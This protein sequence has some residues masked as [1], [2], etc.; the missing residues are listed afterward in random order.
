M[1]KVH[2]LFIYI[3]IGMLTLSACMDDEN[4]SLSKSDLLTFSADSIKLDTIFSTIPSSTR[5]FWVYNKTK[6]GLRCKN[7]RLSNGNQAGFRA[8]VDGTYLSPA[9]GYQVNDI[10]IRKEIV[11]EYS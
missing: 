10:E 4:F 3:T 5:S 1:G 8:N 9:S 11:Y 6:Q 7:I 2:T